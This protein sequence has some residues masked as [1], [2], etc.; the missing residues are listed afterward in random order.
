MC[1][2]VRRSGQAEGGSKPRMLTEAPSW[3]SLGAGG[4]QIAVGGGTV[5]L[6]LTSAKTMR[7]HDLIKLPSDVVGAIRD[8]LILST[9]IIHGDPFH[10][11]CC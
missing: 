7:A 9:T 2:R 10:K 6:K 1:R 5:K 4:T 3:G 11:D 8:M